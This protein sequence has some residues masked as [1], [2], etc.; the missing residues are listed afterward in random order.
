MGVI[1]MNDMLIFL[2]ILMDI[3]H[4]VQLLII[5]FYDIKDITSLYINKFIKIFKPENFICFC[6]L[7]INNFVLY[8]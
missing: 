3:F 8:M 2:K 4:C 6:I 7:N 5:F 1:Y